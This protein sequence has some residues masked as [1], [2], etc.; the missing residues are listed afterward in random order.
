MVLGNTALLHPK[1]LVAAPRPPCLVG[2]TSIDGPLTGDSDVLCLIGIDQG[3]EVPAV[4][5]FPTG[6]Y[7]GVQFRFEGELQDGTFLYDEVDPIL[8]LNGCC[9]ELLSS[10]YD[11]T[12]ATLC[13]TFVNGFLDGFLVFGC[14]TVGLGTKLRY[15]IILVGKLRNADAFLYLLVC[16]LVPAFCLG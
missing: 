6:R 9:Q 2:A 10:R 13:R 4:K 5:T 7:D 16:L 14:R 15:Y 11:D 12:S 8:Q 1:A 3:R